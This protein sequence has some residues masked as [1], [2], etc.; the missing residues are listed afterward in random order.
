MPFP[1]SGAT[2]VAH[3]FILSLK[4]RL[5]RPIN[6]EEQCFYGHIDLEVRRGDDVC[7]HL[8]IEAY[9]IQF[10]ARPLARIVKKTVRDQVVRIYDDVPEL[11]KDGDDHGLPD[12]YIVDLHR[13]EDGD[14]VAVF[15][16]SSG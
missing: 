12:R 10:G 13:D 14:D 1:I 7:A 2:V 9:D 15:Q 16:P 3:K 8:A 4:N 6:I 11:I 5:R